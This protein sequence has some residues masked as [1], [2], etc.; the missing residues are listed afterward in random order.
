MELH[1]VLDYSQDFKI[2]AATDG[3]LILRRLKL[4]W[5]LFLKPQARARRAPTRS[6]QLTVLL[7][8]YTCR[9]EADVHLCPHSS[10]GRARV[11]EARC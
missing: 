1:S 2:E 5:L 9:R 8:R 7:V 6:V 3:Y 10:I 11:Y 4:P